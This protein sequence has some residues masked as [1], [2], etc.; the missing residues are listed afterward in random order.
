MKKKWLSL[1]LALAICLGLLPTTAFAAQNGKLTISFKTAVYSI[2]KET[3]VRWIDEPASQSDC[4]EDEYVTVCVEISNLSGAAVTLQK[5][6][7]R[8]DGGK[9]LYWADLTL[10]AGTTVKLHVFHVHADLLTPGLH[11]VTVYA[12][13][14][15]LYTGRFSIGRDWSEVFKLPTQAQIAAR[16]ADRRSP[17]VVTWLSTGKDVRYDAYSV[18]FKSDHIPYGT[19]SSLF[20]GYMDYSSLKGQCSSVDNDGHISLYGGLQQGDKGKPSNFILSFWDIYCTDA[21][22]NTTIIRPKRIY[23][24]EATGDDS[25]T[26]EGDGA[27]TILPYN[28]QAGRWYRM[29][30]QCGTSKT[31]GNTTVE[32]W[33]QDLTTGE[34][35]HTCTYDIGVKNSGFIGNMAIFSENFLKQYAGEVRSLE[36]TNVRIHTS[37]GWR[38]VVNTSVGIDVQTGAGSLVGAYG[39]WEAGADGNTFYMISTGVSGWGRTEKTGK[40]TI[41]NRE[42]GD[43]LKLPVAGPLKKP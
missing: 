19:Y 5:P 32:Q 35:T 10:K 11:T 14:E 7:I 30:L 15:P 25:F 13:G 12:E 2:S 37:G 8:I 22:G 26:N 9:Q 40:L 41:Q 27:H 4:G 20:N 23:P 42:S 21:A 3:F 16:P 29:L 43:P 34:W 6:C 17:Y 39:S 31:T 1:A 24:A 38:D 36:F 28:W 33:F 18:D